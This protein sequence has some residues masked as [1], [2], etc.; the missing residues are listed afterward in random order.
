MKPYIH[1]TN[2]NLKESLISNAKGMNAPEWVFI[3]IEEGFNNPLWDSKTDFNGCNLVQDVLHPSVACYVHDYLIN[4]GMG[5]FLCDEIA[6]NL[7]I[8]EGLKP[9]RAKRR[10]FA[11]RVAWLTYLK[12]K[13]L[14][15]SNIVQKQFSGGVQAYLKHEKN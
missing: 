1:L 15:S 14:I 3:M 5:G 2:E 13:N 10:W 6:L 4:C 9:S 12:W 7:W 8:M 11:V